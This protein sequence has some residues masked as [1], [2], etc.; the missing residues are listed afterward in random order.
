MAGHPLRPATHRC[1]GGPLPRQLANETR[2]HPKATACKQRPPFPRTFK[3]EAY[4]VLAA[5]SR[6]YPNLLG[7]L[8]TRYSPVRRS[9]QAPKDPF[10]LDLHVLGT[11]PAFN[12]SQD[13]TLQL[14]TIECDPRHKN[15]KVNVNLTVQFRPTR[16]SIVK[17]LPAAFAR[18]REVV[19]ALPATR[20]EL[21]Q[22]LA[23]YL[24]FFEEHPHLRFRSGK[25]AFKDPP[26]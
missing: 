13:Q 19:T 15:S 21:F 20:Q 12:L 14:K 11:P 2:T 5:V 16:Y 18:R 4:P 3:Y 1:L 26:A 22:V 7:R 8:S 10:S 6:C 23:A 17:E 9:T 25:G 24:I